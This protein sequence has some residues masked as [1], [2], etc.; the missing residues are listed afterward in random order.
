MGKSSTRALT[1]DEAAVHAGVTKRVILDACRSGELKNMKFGH[2][3]VRIRP[4]WLQSWIDH[5][6][7]SA[8]Q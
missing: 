6:T 1:P 4:E 8:S 7:R 5:H 3:T 2:R